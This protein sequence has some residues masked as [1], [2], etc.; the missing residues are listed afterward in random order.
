MGN[1]PV[2]S[3]PPSYLVSHSCPFPHGPCTY[4][5]LSFPHAQLNRHARTLSLSVSS[6]SV[7]RQLSSSVMGISCER[8]G[9]R[10]Q[11]H[12]GADR[13]LQMRQ[14]RGRMSSLFVLLTP[15]LCLS[16]LCLPT[17]TPVTVRL[18]TSAAT[19]PARHQIL[20]SSTVYLTRCC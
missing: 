1:E 3:L 4:L 9:P 15:D 7:T 18:L 2:V 10:W 19:R 5:P 12:E 13:R 8:S 14:I 6:A 16:S 17:W 11:L 20:K